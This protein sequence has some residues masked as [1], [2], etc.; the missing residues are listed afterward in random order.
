VCWG[1]G[2][3]ARSNAY[4][5]AV[6]CMHGWVKGQGTMTRSIATMRKSLLKAIYVESFRAFLAIPDS[7]VEIYPHIRR[8]REQTHGLLVTTVSQD[9]KCVSPNDPSIPLYRIPLYRIPSLWRGK[10]QRGRQ[11]EGGMQGWKGKA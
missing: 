2:E 10:R 1:G 5:Y 4:A 3:P 11:M 9:S 6:A 7:P 8:V